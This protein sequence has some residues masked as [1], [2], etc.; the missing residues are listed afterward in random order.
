MSQL[1]KQ[2]G[3]IFLCLKSGTRLSQ[4]CMTTSYKNYY[5]LLETSLLHSANI[6]LQPLFGAH[7]FGKQM[8]PI[9]CFFSPQKSIFR[10]VDYRCLT[11]VHNTKKTG[12][13]GKTHKQCFIFHFLMWS[14][15]ISENRLQVPELYNL[16]Q[17]TSKCTQTGLWLGVHV[18]D[19]RSPPFSWFFMS[20]IRIRL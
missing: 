13:Q 11:S 18:E 17:P 4:S 9:R 2:L 7:A 6:L 16:M 19:V 5:S 8:F 15:P 12:A 14:C 3:F 1:I 20:Y 10:L